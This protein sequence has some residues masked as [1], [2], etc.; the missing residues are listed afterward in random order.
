MLSL[1]ERTF[2]NLVL[3][4]AVGLFLVLEM[5]LT[6]AVGKLLFSLAGGVLSGYGYFLIADKFRY[7]EKDQRRI[8]KLRI[9]ILT[10]VTFL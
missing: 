7:L 6:Y 8:T 9:G 1:R 2:L 10:S 3:L 4:C 5:F